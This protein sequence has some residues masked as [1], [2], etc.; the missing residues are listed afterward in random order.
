MQYIK[1]F[2]YIHSFKHIIVLSLIFFL[3]GNNT[4]TLLINIT[5]YLNLIEK[6]NT[7]H[8]RNYI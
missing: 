5:I 8:F 4:Y 6:P 7:L 3:K 2:N 1:F